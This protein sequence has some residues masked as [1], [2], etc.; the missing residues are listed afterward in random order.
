[1]TLSQ[2]GDKAV[3]LQ[4]LARP[5]IPVVDHSSTCTQYSVPSAS[6]VYNNPAT[7]PASTRNVAAIF[8]VCARVGTVSR[9]ETRNG[10]PRYLLQKTTMTD[11][12]ARLTIC[13][14]TKTMSSMSAAWTRNSLDATHQ[15]RRRDADAGAAA[16]F[17]QVPEAAEGSR[18]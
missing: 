4:P 12:A 13:A 9:R 16:L 5:R 2:V 3:D 6:V 17:D 14:A 11:P 8:R 15:T 18:R 1:M 10:G 7:P